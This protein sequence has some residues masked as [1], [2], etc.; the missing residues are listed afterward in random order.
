MGVQD[1]YVK[2]SG[3]LRLDEPAAD[4]GILLALASALTERPVHPGTAVLGE[5]GLAGEVRAVPRMDDRVREAARLGFAR[6]IVP[7]GAGEG[8][9][10]AAGQGRVVAVATVRE[11]MEAALMGR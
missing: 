2:V 6:C 1:V 7:R 5:V 9:T 8:N 10:G 11:A 4:L 3:G